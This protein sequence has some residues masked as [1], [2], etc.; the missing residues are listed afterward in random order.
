MSPRI[1]QVPVS[2]R[3]R[4]HYLRELHRVEVE[5]ANLVKKTQSAYAHAHRLACEEWNARQFIGGPAE[6]SPAIQDAIDG[7]CV[8]LEV[9]CKS[10]C[11]TQQIDLVEVIWPRERPLHSLA[12]ALECQQCKRA[13][14]KKRRPELVRVD[15]REPD[16][17]PPHAA[18]QRKIG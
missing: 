1:I 11:H 2:G 10:C 17:Q 9:R 7:G 8:L 12:N 4:R 15:L 18:R 14:Y 3:D 5:H 16:L 13:G 6:P